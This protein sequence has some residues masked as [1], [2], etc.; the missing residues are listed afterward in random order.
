[1]RS[2]LKREFGAQKPRAIVLDDHA[3][4]RGATGLRLRRKGFHVD[5]F[6]TI[7]SFFEQWRPGTVD[8]IVADWQLSDDPELG[9][10]YVLRHVREL[11]WSVPF[12]LVSGK[13]ADDHKRADVLEALLSGGSAAFVTRGSGGIAE[14][15]DV[16]EALVEKRDVALS[17]VILAIRPAALA[18]AVLQTSSGPVSAQEMLSRLVASPESFRTAGAP[19]A[20]S[21][22]RR[23]DATA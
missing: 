14:A 1:M 22:Q 5:E 13:L 6:A 12:V 9:G 19:V 16:A 20:D 23:I 17:K 18:G 15:C 2:T 21:I 7:G 4:S 8:V 3:G 11:D 10:D